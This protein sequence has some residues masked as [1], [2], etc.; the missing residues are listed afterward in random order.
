MSSLSGSDSAPVEAVPKLYA[1]YKAAADWVATHPDE[2]AKL[3][4]PKGSPEDQKAVADLIRANDRLGLNVRW[5]GEVRKEIEAVYAAGKQ[6][7]FLG[8]DPAK[9]TVYQAP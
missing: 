1:T 2:A 8:G 6:I 9:A 3:I 4:S 7:G 5:A